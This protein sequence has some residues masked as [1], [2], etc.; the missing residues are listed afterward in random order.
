MAESNEEERLKMSSKLVSLEQHFARLRESSQKR[1]SRLEEALK[2]ASS[3]EDRSDQFDKWL[4]EAEGRKVGMGPLTISSQP[5]KTQLD[6]MQVSS[7][8][9]CLSPPKP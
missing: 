1:M 3:Y 2:L 5:L 9:L 4:C 8:P 6:I 7:S